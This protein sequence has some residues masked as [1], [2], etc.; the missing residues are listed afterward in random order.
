MLYFLFLIILLALLEKFIYI[1]FLSKLIL[2]NFE[3]NI[4]KVII[5][6]KSRPYLSRIY[7]KFLSSKLNSGFLNYASMILLFF[8][9]SFGSE[10]KNL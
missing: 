6:K 4:F 9:K 2:V 5:R 1:S 8:A 3:I 10:G 7:S